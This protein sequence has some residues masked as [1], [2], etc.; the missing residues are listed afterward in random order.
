[1]ASLQAKKTEAKFSAESTRQAPQNK[2]KRCMR[3]AQQGQPRVH[4]ANP[5]WQIVEL[6]AAL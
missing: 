4:A 3:L 2:S 5:I 6:Y 1:M